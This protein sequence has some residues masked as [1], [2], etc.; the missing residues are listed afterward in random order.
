MR[1]VTVAI[2][3]SAAFV[4]ACLSHEHDLF[5]RGCGGKSHREHLNRRQL[6]STAS[7][8]ATPDT[9]GG[10]SAAGYSC[11]SST[12][13]APACMCASTKP[14]GNLALS[15]VPQ[16]I[17]LT[18][19]DAIQS[20]TIDALNKLVTGR[21]N[22]NG[23]PVST[24]YFTSLDYTNY[25][26]VTDFYVAGNEIADHTITHVGTPNISEVSGNLI[27]LNALAG[28]PYKELAG[29]RAPFLNYSVATLQDLSK[30]KFT[31]DS[32]A[33][34]SVAVTDNNT[35]AF[36]P[37]TLDNG[38]AN[39]C[40]VDGLT[41]V[42]QG[43]PKI[44][45][46]WEIPMY[47][48]FNSDKTILGLMDPWLEVTDN[49][50]TLAA[51][52]ATFT[53]HYNAQKQP[54][55][56][57][58]HPIHISTTYPGAPVATNT[59]IVA[60]LNQFLDFALASS[61]FQN[62]WMINN[63]QLLAWMKNPVPASQL[64]TLEEFQCQTPNPSQAKLCS[65][66][67]AKEDS[68]IIKCISDTPGDS[69]NNSP[70][71]TCYGCPTVRPTPDQPNPPQKNNDGSVRIR[72]GDNCDTPFWDPVAG[73]CLNSGYTDDTRA[74]GPNGANLTS[75]ATTNVANTTGSAVDGYETFGGAASLH[76]SSRATAG[77]LGL[78]LLLAV[79][80]LYL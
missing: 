68:L 57:Y 43:L 24:T 59:A 35:D 54:F 48:T 1:L 49:S 36:W 5:S 33:T 21:K 72:I 6:A 4:P 8:G 53:D 26:M 14:P 52:K 38:L 40:Q 64:N 58:S 19:D 34:S 18:A 7:E 47:S 79:V 17:T 50:K 32:S 3:L 73:K 39:D 56:L 45:G 30:Q 78:S 11:D 23:C 46:L 10:A 70:F 63:K 2:A 55:G 25:S 74:I 12:C 20:Y 61:Q 16:F 37:Y 80:S 28:I 66:I 9:S 67:P 75:S 15:D 42:C 41:G 31:Y 22:P 76:Q 13:K 65:G 44:P 29:F 62:V 51:L 60:T 27:A 69:L 71:N 77:C